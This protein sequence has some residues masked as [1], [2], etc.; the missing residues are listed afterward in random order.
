MTDLCSK[1]SNNSSLNDENVKCWEKIDSSNATN[2]STLSLCISAYENLNEASSGSLNKS[3]QKS[4]L[5][6]KQKRINSASTLVSQIPFE[7]QRQQNDKVPEPKVSQYK[8]S[9]RL[10][11]LKKSDLHSNTA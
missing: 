11:N 1:Y 8:A 9:Q 5:I 4:L 6:Q 10:L 7:F 2:S 3:F